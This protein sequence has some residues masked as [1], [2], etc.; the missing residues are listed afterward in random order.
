MPGRKHPQEV[1]EPLPNQPRPRHRNLQDRPAVLRKASHTQIPQ[2]CNYLVFHNDL[3]PNYLTEAIERSSRLSFYF[4]HS[5]YFYMVSLEKIVGSEEI[6][7]FKKVSDYK[8]R[9]LEEMSRLY[10]GQMLNSV[11]FFIG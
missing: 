2:L 8:G 3:K 5:Y 11:E 4:A 1:C 10:E 9:F 7:I 6:Q